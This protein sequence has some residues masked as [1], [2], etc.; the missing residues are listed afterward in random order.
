MDQK[1]QTEIKAPRKLEK[2]TRDT[3]E[4]D[5]EELVTYADENGGEVTIP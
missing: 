4:L 5:R 3:A 2:P 1:D